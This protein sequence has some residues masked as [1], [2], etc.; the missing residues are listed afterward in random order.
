MN[1][2]IIVGMVIAFVA[3]AMVPAVSADFTLQFD[4]KTPGYTYDDVVKAHNAGGTAYIKKAATYVSVTDLMS[5]KT[6]GI[7]QKCC[8]AN[9]ITSEQKL[10]T[11]KD[12]WVP[13]DPVMKQTFKA[14]NGNLDAEIFAAYKGE[15]TYGGSRLTM[16]NATLGQDISAKVKELQVKASSTDFSTVVDFWF[17]TTGPCHSSDWDVS[18]THM[19]DISDGLSFIYSIDGQG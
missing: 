11:E 13:A 7:S 19:W 18:T 17:E 16:E 3:I 12:T 9:Y 10:V 6:V 8:N 14:C 15:L 1:T 5:V 4:A 2:K